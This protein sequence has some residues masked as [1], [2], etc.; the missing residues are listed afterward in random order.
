MEDYIIELSEDEVQKLLSLSEHLHVSPSENADSFCKMAK[1]LSAFIPSRIRTKVNEFITRGSISGFLLIRRIP[2]D[3]KTLPKTPPDNQSKIG[4]G[5]VLAKIQAML[6]HIAG[7]MIAYEG[8]GYGRIFQDIVPMRNMANN[9]TSLGSNIELEIH[10]EQAF[11]DLRPDILSLACLRGDKEAFTHILPVSRILENVSPTTFN[12]EN[13]E[14]AVAFPLKKRRRVVDLNV[15]R[16]KEESLLYEPLWKTSV[17]L[18]FQLQ[19]Q[20]FEKGL[21][22]GPFAILERKGESPSDIHLLFD[23]DLMIGETEEANTLVSKIVDIYYHHRI[24]HNLKSGEILLIDNRRAIHGRSAF[25]P[26]YNGYDRFLIRGFATLDFK[27]SEYAR[28]SK[29]NRVILSYYS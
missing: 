10:T 24:L 13:T 23:Q 12:V 11:S 18:S 3:F 6:L 5:T 1:Q 25:H 28:D 14:S 16:G 15:E 17:D 26:R 22:R 27:K 7:E 2:I 29:N 21:I 19:T 20:E 8:E 4:E 9:Q